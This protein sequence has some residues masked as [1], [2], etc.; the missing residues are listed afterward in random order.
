MTEQWHRMAK[1]RLEQLPTLLQKSAKLVA[2][3]I[4][5]NIQSGQNAKDNVLEN[6]Y[7]AGERFKPLS[8]LTLKQRKENGISGDK[9]LIAT[10]DMLASIKPHSLSKQRI[11]V[12]PTG[13]KNKRKM[14]A[15]YGTMHTGIFS[16]ITKGYIPTR[17]P[18][19]Y[20]DKVAR[21]I[22]GIA[23]RRLGSRHD[24]HAVL[25]VDYGL[26]I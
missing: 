15:Q 20:S 7:S 26:K 24:F 19:G 16:T 5:K 23:Q 12:G 14:K 4:R 25:N 22:S 17:N 11:R 9:P 8:A 2:E 18:M 21:E 6:D 3:E 13:A 1:A 10:G